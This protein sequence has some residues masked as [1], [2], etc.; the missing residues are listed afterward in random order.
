M[1]V[2]VI[3]TSGIVSRIITPNQDISHATLLH[4][5]RVF[6]SLRSKIRLNVTHIMKKRACVGG[7]CRQRCDAMSASQ[8][9]LLFLQNGTKHKSCGTALHPK[10]RKVPVCSCTCVCL[11]VAATYFPKIK[12]GE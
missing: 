6:T 10:S 3:F 11:T 5:Q 9:C 1:F 2:P 4:T 7:S 8:G 12:I